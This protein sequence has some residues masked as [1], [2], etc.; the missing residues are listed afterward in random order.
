MSASAADTNQKDMR[1]QAIRFFFSF[2][3]LTLA[4]CTD[5]FETDPLVE[6]STDLVISGGTPQRLVRQLGA[7][8][9]LVKIRERDIDL[10]VG[11]DTGS[12]HTELADA[13]LR[14]GLH[15]TVVRLESAS[16]LVVS[17][18]SVDVRSWKGAAAVRIL[19]WPRRAPDTPPDQRLPGYE[20]L[21]AASELIARG[22]PESAR[23]AVEALRT[24]ERHFDLAHDSQALAETEYQRGY[25]EL[26]LLFDHD[27]ARRTAQA[28]L[29]HFRIAG[30]ERGTQRSA[31]L[32]AL[33]EFGSAGRMGPE[34]SR[35]R[36]RALLDA[37]AQRTTEAQIYFE[38]H[39]L[40]SDSLQA[41]GAAQLRNQVLGR[42]EDSAPMF[43]N[44]RKR[45][46]ARGDRYFEAAALRSLGYIAQRQGDLVRAAALYE[47]ALP[48]IE[49]ERKP[50]L[51]ASLI[52]DLGY[53]LIALGEFD[54]A[55][56]L[57][58]E[59][60]ELFSSQGNDSQTAR[61]L[62]A[63]AAIQFRS[64]DLERSL[65]SIE[66]AL[67]LFE[68]AHDEL[69]ESAALRLA[70]NATAELGRHTD[71]LTYLRAAEGGDP[72]GI[73]VDRTRVLIAAELRALGH[74]D[75]ADQVIAQTLLTS[76]QSTR[77]DALVERA[78]LRLRQHREAE[79]LADLRAADATFASLKLDFKRIDS[80]SA[81]AMA[82]L[83]AGDIEGARAAADVA[84]T[85]ERRIRVKAA[86]PEMRARF[87]AASYAPHE[88][89]IEVELAAAPR[90]PAA[91]WRA[92]RAAEA[93]RARSLSDRLV[94]DT[95]PAG[96][97]RDTGIDRLRT[98][99]TALQLDLETRNRR[100]AVSNDELLEVRRRID[101][102]QARLE[103][104][105]LTQDAVR[106]S[107]ELS[108]PESRATVQAALPADT[109]VLAYFVGERRSHAWLL[110]RTGLR[111][112]VLP[113]RRA[114][115][116]LV[117]KFTARQISDPDAAPDSLFA[118][119]SGGLLS[120]I[121][122]KRL[123]VLPDGPL[124]G[125]PFAALP[126]TRAQPRQL[127]V[128]RFVITTA[129]SLALALR[130]APPRGDTGTRVAV[131]SDPVYTPDDRRLTAAVSDSSRFRGLDE[132]SGR[133]A[134]LPYSAIEARAVKRAFAGAQIIE[135]AGFDASAR[136]VFELPARNLHL[137][138]FATHAVV[139]RDAPGQ[140][141]LLLSE[142]SADGTP[143]AAD[144]LTADDVARSGLRADIVVLSGCATGN[145]PEL[146][147]EGVLGLTYDFL[148]NGS[149]AVIASLWPVEDA[150]TARFMEQFY[151][152]Y[153]A[154]G[155]AADALR[156]AQLRTRDADGTAVWSSFFIRSNALP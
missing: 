122:A 119:L 140:S 63:L 64:G 110:T 147:G 32:L 79:A 99:L 156:I 114:L 84:V 24:A 104:R 127:L 72:N 12:T 33:G 133:L 14:H 75:S 136:R 8:V 2:A 135:L 149:D 1:T 146:R 118:P 53:A 125:L 87:L 51:Y 105:L 107:D 16:R 42:I 66:S 45:A 47:S 26:A 80:S 144:R 139:R 5:G 130:P 39:D 153:R 155:R 65:A 27:A 111:H 61:E 129:P 102:T 126:L 35:A 151:A 141:A 88:A 91:V 95:R 56:L 7:G 132:Q 89:R 81:L 25:V 85:M 50:E 71:A 120:G 48:L 40:A 54:R 106:A 138:H 30:D 77:A 123:L 97:Q 94:H 36:Q 37:A 29:A 43:E 59:A 19:R 22:T 112:A 86:N 46:R 11:I 62:V 121:S 124:N 137:L 13:Y 41:L 49:R 3:L 52:G 93:I 67:P 23:A 96:A 9:Y 83:D 28:A 109:A 73:N 108:I 31:I 117:H 4:A 10:R 90:D 152:A 154:T 142:F 150:L 55:L 148:A 115:E 21:G 145:G 76:D 17:L 34:V 44:L 143:Q 70:G 57:H 69:G 68:R 103:A 78:L 116:D 101:E 100:D 82:L 18:E 74:L 128:D 15:R 38:T 131:V 60:L 98:T 58:T 6:F 92:F 113:G 20:A 134:R